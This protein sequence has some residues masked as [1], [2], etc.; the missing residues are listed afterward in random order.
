MIENAE[1]LRI[2]LVKVNRW[3]QTKSLGNQVIY[4][5]WL[6]SGQFLV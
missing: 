4:K 2:L 5:S 6:T 1:F 3:L